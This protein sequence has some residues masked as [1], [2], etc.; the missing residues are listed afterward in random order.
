MQFDP[1]EATYSYLGFEN[2][3][4]FSKVFKKV[5]GMSPSEFVADKLS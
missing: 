1:N 5:S 4:Y 2:T 3:Y